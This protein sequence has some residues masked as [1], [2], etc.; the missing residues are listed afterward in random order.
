[1]SRAYRR[2][3]SKYEIFFKK[4]MGLKYLFQKFRGSYVKFIN[5]GGFSWIITKF[6][7]FFKNTYVKIRGLKTR[8]LLSAR[9]FLQNDRCSPDLGRP[10][11][12]RG[13]AHLPSKFKVFFLKNSAL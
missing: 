6:K 9:V 11:G 5:C 8:F 7:V 1:M 12:R 13:H 3:V 4:N 10:A 2:V